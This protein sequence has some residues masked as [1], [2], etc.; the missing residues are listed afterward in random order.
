MRIFVPIIL[1]F[2]F[3]A[4]LLEKLF[5]KYKKNRPEL[6]RQQEGLLGTL[7]VIVI[8]HS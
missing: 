3:K 8:L 2:E 7:Q 5:Q 6:H 1:E 4:N